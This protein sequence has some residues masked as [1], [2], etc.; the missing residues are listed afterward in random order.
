[1]RSVPVIQQLV[2]KENLAEKRKHW[3]F[4]YH[5]QLVGFL[6]LLQIDSKGSTIL[7]GFE[8]GVVRILNLQQM[9]GTDQ[10][11][12]KLTDQSELILRQA[13]KPHTDQVTALAVDHTGEILAT[14][15]SNKPLLKISPRLTR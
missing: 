2:V 8:D 7:V 14:A 9:E 1:M 5:N 6:V 13:L 3:Y 15:V 4:A 12:H 10:H 11:G